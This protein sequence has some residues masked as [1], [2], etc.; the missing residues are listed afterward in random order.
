MS[1]PRAQTVAGVAFVVAIAGAVGVRTAR[2]HDAPTV[3]LRI[4]SRSDGVVT[5]ARLAGPQVLVSLTLP[6]SCHAQGRDRGRQLD[7]AGD[8]PATLRCRPSWTHESWSFQGLGTHAHAVVVRFEGTVS[9]VRTVYPPNPAFRID[10]NE[11]PPVNLARAASAGAHHVATGLDHLALVALLMAAASRLRDA[12]VPMLGFTLAH[13]ITLGFAAYGHPAMPTRLAEVLVAA[14]LVFAAFLRRD[15]RMVPRTT[16]AFAFGLVHGVAFLEGVA[17]LLA[18]TP[19]PLAALAAF[20]VGIEA[21]QLAV[22]LVIAGAFAGL[23]RCASGD[24]AGRFLVR[25][26]GGAYGIALF[27]SRIR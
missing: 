21:V 19:S 15:E 10:E 22:A 24:D 1:R 7:L 8:L 11:T 23:R 16:T 18:T 3:A 25:I 20:H 4:E 26:V 2:A 6:P 5:V 14:S 17:P 9:T 13:A 27:A 12:L